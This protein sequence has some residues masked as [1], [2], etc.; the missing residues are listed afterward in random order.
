MLLDRQVDELVA[1][2][3]EYALHC[4]TYDSTCCCGCDGWHKYWIHESDCLLLAALRLLRDLGKPWE[5]LEGRPLYSDISAS[6]IEEAGY[7]HS[8]AI[9]AEI[10][11]KLN[12]K[13][14]HT[15]RASTDSM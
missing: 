3:N 10:M 14:T 1:V 9:R 11:A 2:L 4:T 6:E 7:I 5:W 13:M 12:A 15:P 8:A